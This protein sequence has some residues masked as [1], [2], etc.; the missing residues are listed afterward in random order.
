MNARN[1][2]VVLT[3][4]GS[5][6][7][8]AAEDKLRSQAPGFEASIRA[9]TNIVFRQFALGQENKKWQVFGVSHPREVRRLTSSVHLGVETGNRCEFIQQ[10]KFQGPS[11][12]VEVLFNEHYF[13]VVDQPD[14]KAYSQH[15]YQM[16]KEFYEQFDK[17][18]K[19]HPW[20]VEKP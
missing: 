10:A 6:L 16:P 8:A 4:T 19:Q 5:V 20:H 7:V 17:L 13:V 14:P 9:A 18:A 12:T 11:G 15:T 2:I 3:M 1:L